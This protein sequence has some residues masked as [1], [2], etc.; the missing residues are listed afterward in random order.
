LTRLPRLA[1]PRT[2]L[3]AIDISTQLAIGRWHRSPA[4]R[5]ASPLVMA[6]KPTSTGSFL[7]DRWKRCREI[8]LATETGIIFCFGFP[9]LR[10]PHGR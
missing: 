9:G 5:P 7:P 10:S 1:C 6:Y 2:G 3:E 4:R 8:R